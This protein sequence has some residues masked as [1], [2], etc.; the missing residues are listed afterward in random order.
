MPTLYLVGTPIGNLEDMSRR[1]VRILGEVGLIAAEDTRTTAKLLHHYQIA[2]PL[3]S[4]HDFSGPERQNQLL[5]KL[6]VMDVA[7]VSEAGMPGLSDPGYRLVT[8]A[9][10][11]GI[12]IVPIPGP[13]AAVLALVSSGLPTDSFLF[14]GFLPRQEKARQAALTA[15]A[16]LPYTLVLY[17]SPRRILALLADIVAT[18]GDRPVA[19]GRELTKLY[20][21]IW[22]GTAS[23]AAAY[24]AAKGT[25]GEFTLVVGGAAPAAETWSE[26]AVR[27]ALRAYVAQGLT[28]KE[29]AVKVAAESG[30]RKR[31]I[32]KPDWFE[33]G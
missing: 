11:A 25:R 20:E 8:A 1:A 4:Y 7:L 31:D 16:Q 23:E 18:L 17:E 30:W 19:V 5:Q 32:Y 2:T 6:A 14:L 13:A 12:P 29:A 24:F 33:E 10:D 3:V 15:V 21:E 26:T 28:R 22:R 27:Q 9:I